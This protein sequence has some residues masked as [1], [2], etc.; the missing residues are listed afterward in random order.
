M[1]PIVRLSKKTARYSL[2]ETDL[3]AVTP[4]GN[5][6]DIYEQAVV[7]TVAGFF[8][9]NPTHL[10]G[11]TRFGA[12][13]VYVRAGSIQLNEVAWPQSPRAESGQVIPQIV[14]SAS[15]LPVSPVPFSSLNR[16]FSCRSLSPG[17]AFAIGLSLA[18]K[19]PRPSA[20]RGRAPCSRWR[21]PCR[22]GATRL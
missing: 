14:A 8:R 21:S 5:S 7:K 15:C 11:V 10:F 6:G 4:M 2:N 9:G 3:N 1:S 17:P 20:E 13:V 16:F 22:S 18:P 19:R 12:P